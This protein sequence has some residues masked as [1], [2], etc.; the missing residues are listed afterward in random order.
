MK[1]KAYKAYVVGSQTSKSLSPTIFNYWFKKYNIE[2]EYSFLEVDEKK[3]EEE[4]K[5]KFEDPSVCG[6]NITIPFK[7]KVVSLISETD[8]HSKLIGAVNCITK[9]KKKLFGKNTDWIGFKKSILFFEKKTKRINRNKATIIGYGGSSK[10][11]LYALNNMGYLYVDLW[12]RSFDKI[13]NITRFD[14]IK[15]YPKKLDIKIFDIDMNSSIVINTIPTNYYYK[16]NKNSFLKSSN[17]F[18]Y[19]LVYNIRTDFLKRFPKTKQ[20][21]GISLL[22]HQAAPCFELWFNKK[23]TIDEDLY[24]ILYKKLESF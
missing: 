18:G 12:N 20:V 24:S 14:K 16:N 11:I 17:T 1:K 4:I 7:E 19:D 10:A 5:K 22:V 6:L 15:I 23:P 13:E 3:F 9:N 8:N 2:G 21:H